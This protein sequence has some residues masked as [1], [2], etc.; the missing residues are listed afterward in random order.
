M[1]LTN[2]IKINITNNAKLRTNM[3]YIFAFTRTIRP[4]N[5]SLIYNLK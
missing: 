1:A 5:I 2:Y 4:K 3:Q